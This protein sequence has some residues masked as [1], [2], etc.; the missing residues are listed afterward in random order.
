MELYVRRQFEEKYGKDQIE[1]QREVTWPLG[2]GHIDIYVRSEKLIVEVV[3]TV[4]GS[5]E[6]KIRQARLYLMHDPEALNAAVYI[7]NPSS[8]SGEE[9]L[10]VYT[11]D[12][13]IIDLQDRIASVQTAVDGGPLP[14]CVHNSPSG[15]AHSG[16]PFYKTA[17]EGWE[18]P[19]P[20]DLS[21][22]P[23]VVRLAADYYHA[24]KAYREAKA[25]EEERKAT[26]DALKDDLVELLPVGQDVTAGPLSVRRIHVTGRETLSWSKARQAG[27]PPGVEEIL[28]PFVSISDGYSRLQIKRVSDDPITASNDFGDVP[29]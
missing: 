19:D 3:S 14:D 27:L 15:C 17:W 20:V 22:S 16:C 25:L 4:G 11:S 7:V 10:P 6:H 5:I 21:D 8:L 1:A 13:D 28:Q 29:F 23:A 18:P 2:T 24:D 9:F 12:Q 26:R